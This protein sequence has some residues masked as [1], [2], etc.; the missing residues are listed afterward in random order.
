[1]GKTKEERKRDKIKKLKKKVRLVAINE[2]TF[3]ELWSVR[4]SGFNALGVLLT[5]SIVVSVLTYVL[6]AY[7]SLNQLLPYNANIEQDF[8]LLELEEQKDSLAIMVERQ[9]AYL[10]GIRQMLSG[11]TSRSILDYNRDSVFSLELA[12]KDLEADAQFR[13]MYYESVDSNA[14]FNSS[15]MDKLAIAD[16]LTR[17]L[18]GV[19]SDSFSIAKDHFGIDVVAAPK[20]P[21]K[22]V[23][24]GFVSAKYW[25][26]EDGNVLIIQHNNNAI[27]IYKHLSYVLKNKGDMISQGEAV[28]LIGNTGSHS[29]GTHLHFEYWKNGTAIDPLTLFNF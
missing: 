1:M 23:D 24:E 18:S 5:F 26:P 25:S 29:S 11:D 6:L 12:E 8:Q 10:F 4:L 2:S 15:V 27:S 21:I 17:P 28:G 14:V 3:E 16:F 22:S 19:V 7:T 20:S 13:N 9:E